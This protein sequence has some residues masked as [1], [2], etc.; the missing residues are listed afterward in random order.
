[1]LKRLWQLWGS[2]WVLWTWGRVRVCEFAIRWFSQET[3][4][5]L[6][7]TLWGCRNCLLVAS[8]VTALK[9]SWWH[10]SCRGTENISEGLWGWN[11]PLG[12]QKG[13]LWLQKP[14]DIRQSWKR[15]EEERVCEPGSPW[16]QLRRCSMDGTGK[17]CQEVTNTT[18]ADWSN[19]PCS[20]WNSCSWI[21]SYICRKM[22][23][24]V[25]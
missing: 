4:L 21:A 2:S 3:F 18:F 10:D 5:V 9:R 24:T 23:L 22:F 25:L 15:A 1:M 14:G 12:N 16:A 8:V 13:R 19:P 11:S 6:L 20:N 7:V 17:L